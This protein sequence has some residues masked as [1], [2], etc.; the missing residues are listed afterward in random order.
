MF[1]GYNRV[2]GDFRRHNATWWR[3]QMET[4]SALLALC[5]GNSPVTGEFP[6]QRPVTQSFRVFFD[7]RL[8]KRLSIQSRRGELGRLRTHYDVTVMSSCGVTVTYICLINTETKRK[9][10]ICAAIF[11]T[12]NLEM[13]VRPVHINT[14]VKQT[15]CVVAYSVTPTHSVSCTHVVVRNPEMRSQPQ[16]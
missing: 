9:S 8:N 14:S 2:A 16:K 7:L 12:S 3:N 1:T 4:F 13:I 15:Q 11:R 10:H 5:V 6:L